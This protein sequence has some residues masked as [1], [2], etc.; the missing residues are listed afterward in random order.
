M[1]EKL[2]NHFLEFAMDF[3]FMISC[4]YLQVA[5]IEY[6]RNVLKNPEASSEEV[7]QEISKE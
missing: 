5:V 3:R 2:K 1:Q 4:K 7:L 6:A